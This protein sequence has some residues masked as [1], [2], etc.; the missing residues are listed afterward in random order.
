MTFDQLYAVDRATFEDVFE[1]AL[2][3]QVYGVKPWQDRLRGAWEQADPQL[4]ADENLA[5]FI[6]AILTWNGRAEKDSTGILPYRYWKAQA[7]AL[8]REVGNR[9]GSPPMLWL[10][11]K[12]VLQMIKDGCQAM[13]K[14]HGRIEVKYGDVYRCGRKGGKRTTPAEGGSI[15]S[16]SSP[17]ALSFDQKLDHGQQLMEGGQCALQI[18]AMTKPP[19]SWTAAPLGQSDDPS[20]PHFDDQAIELVGKRKLKSTYFQ[21]KSELLKHVESKKELVY[22]N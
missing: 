14:E 1:L 6:Q 2:S 4:K 12:T 7:S 17:R 8:D 15:N 3:P 13:I 10:T 18:V 9:L 16:I 11:D 21:D 22:Q 20:S 5:R 19:Q